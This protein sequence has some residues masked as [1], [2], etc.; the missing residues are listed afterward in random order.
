MTKAKVKSLRVTQVRSAI[1]F[2]K[3]QKATVRALGIRRMQD[4]VELPD[5]PQVRGMIGKIQHLLKVEDA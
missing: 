2:P 1:G 3:D 5:T 4:T